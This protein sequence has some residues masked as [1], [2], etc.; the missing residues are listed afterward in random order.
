MIVFWRLFLSLYMA[1]FLLFH[2]LPALELQNRT[3]ATAI[4]TGIF[5]LFA[6]LL[7]RRYLLLKWPFFGVIDLPGWLCILLFG[8]FFVCVHQ[9]FNF[10][11]QMRF[12]HL[13]TF[14]VKNT[15]LWLFLFLCTPFLVLYRTGNFF[16]QPWMIFC[17]GT[18]IATRL[19]DE[20]ITAIEQDFHA[21][22]LPT[23][24]EQWM[25]MMVRLIFFLIMLLPGVRWLIFF[26]IWLG[27][28]MYARRIRL[29]D[30]THTAFYLGVAGASL[31][32]LLVR[33]RLYWMI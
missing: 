33:L 28:C 31:I 10:G 25:L 1:D 18:V 3:R 4:R 15:F 21:S 7:C 5:L 14:V 13:L 17:V 24:D 16:A 22:P 12:G 20:L 11:G 27:T 32:G 23:F 30:V 2:K 29:M 9:W 19:L 8:A 6:F 26:V